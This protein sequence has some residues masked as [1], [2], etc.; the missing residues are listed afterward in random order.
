MPF[1]DTNFI[2]DLTRGDQGAIRIAKDVDLRDEIK[3]ISVVSVHEYLRGIYYKFSESRKL[4]DK[5]KRA[6]STLGYF[7]QVPISVEIAR[8][9]AEIDAILI[10]KGRIIPLADVYIGTSA[11]HYGLPLV[12]RDRHFD[13][14]PSLQLITY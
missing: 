7:D 10:K 11:L 2:I 14:F 5:L 9:A 3:V 1:F 4:D 12:T 8:R 13:Q 6:L